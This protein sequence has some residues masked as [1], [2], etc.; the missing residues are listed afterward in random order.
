MK[1]MVALLAEVDQKTFRMLLLSFARNQKSKFS[2]FEFKIHKIQGLF[3]PGRGIWQK[4]C[5][6][7]GN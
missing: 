6:I 1:T 4:L 3:Y 7:S 2:L 5:K